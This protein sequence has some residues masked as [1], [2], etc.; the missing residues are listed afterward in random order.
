MDTVRPV[1]KVDA[2]GSL[3]LS[4]DY[5]GSLRD[6]TP[7]D[8]SLAQSHKRATSEIGKAGKAIVDQVVIPT[9]QKV[10][11]SS[12]RSDRWCLLSEF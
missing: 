9:L 4:A 8:D 3:R 5:V 6:K 7:S 11:S 1:K 12:C 10:T 2:T